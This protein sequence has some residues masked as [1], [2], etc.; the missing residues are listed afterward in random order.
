MFNGIKQCDWMRVA[1]WFD[2]IKSDMTWFQVTHKHTHANTHSHIHKRNTPA[3][4]LFFNRINVCRQNENSAY[5]L[6][7]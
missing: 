2:W 5:Y 7:K 6:C 3:H 4:W 1:H